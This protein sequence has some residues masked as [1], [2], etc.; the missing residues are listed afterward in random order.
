M[1]TRSELMSRRSS[2]PEDRERKPA[3]RQALVRFLLGCA[4]ALVILAAGTVYVGGR[5]AEEQALSEARN[6][7]KLLAQRVAAP[8]VTEA[9]RQG[10]PQ[11]RHR[12]ESAMRERLRDGSIKHIKL[13]DPDG[14]VLW[15]DESNMIGH[16]YPIDP[17]DRKLF[18]TTNATADVSTLD[19][20]ENANERASGELLEVYAGAVDGSRR[21][22]MFEAYLPLDTLHRQE[23]AIITGVLP[24]GIGGLLLFAIFVLPMAIRLSRRVERHEAERSKM[25]RHALVASELERRRI[26]QELHDGVI[27]DLAGITFALPTV[28]ASLP[29]DEDGDEA[30][31]TVDSV[32]ELVQKDATALR[33]MLVELYPPDLG[34]KG[35]AMAVRDIARSA[36][37]QGVAVK[38]DVDPDLVVPLDVAT[39]AYRVIREGLRNVVKHARATAAEVRMRVD[40]GRLDVVVAD[41]GRGVDPSTTAERGHFGLQLLRDTVSDLG[42][43]LRLGANEPQ[44][45]VL[46][47]SIPMDLIP[48]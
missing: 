18:G 46:N 8:L 30:R 6:V 45:A 5:I 1:T 4:L 3:V 14:T 47:V 29:D 31:E 41:D 22:I 44:G 36:S 19:K 48:S 21:P 28:A 32:T 12:L 10:N 15:S 25:M 9:F 35:F 27:Q 7:A 33:S 43:T 11:A 37:E 38:V 39:L 2:A 26:A 17:E 24:V 42:G 34:G 16:Q 13:W 23:V 20:K 40:S